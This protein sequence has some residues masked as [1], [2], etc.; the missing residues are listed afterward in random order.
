M[1]ILHQIV[2]KAIYFLVLHITSS[3]NHNLSS[4]WKVKEVTWVQH[5][6]LQVSNLQREISG[7]D[8]ISGKITEKS[9]SH[10]E[11]IM[12]KGGADWGEG[13][14]VLGT[15]WRADID[16]TSN[17]KNMFLVWTYVYSWLAVVCRRKWKRKNSGQIMSQM[18]VEAFGSISSIRWEK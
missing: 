1:F 11:K 6:L 15:A 8:P 18:P 5:P 7:Y 4:C 14:L 12:L 16:N 2:L 10:W 17:G 13:L 9:G 3:A